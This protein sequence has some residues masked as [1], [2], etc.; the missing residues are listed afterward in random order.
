MFAGL[1]NPT[2]STLTRQLLGWQPSHVGLIDDLTH[3][4]YFDGVAG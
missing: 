1:D 4:H 3:G 2:S